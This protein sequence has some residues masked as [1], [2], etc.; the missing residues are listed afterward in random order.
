MNKIPQFT[1]TPESVTVTEGDNV[2]L[3]ASAVGK[4]QPK[5]TWTKAGEDVVQG[6]SEDRLSDSLETHSQ[7]QFEDINPAL[8]G[9][10][11]TVKAENAYGSVTHDVVLSGRI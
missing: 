10:K 1:A 9:G 7:L 5:I 3:S 2:S 6:V 4:P 11:Y 8:S